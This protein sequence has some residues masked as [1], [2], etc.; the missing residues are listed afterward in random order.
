M[1]NNPKLLT[2]PYVKR[3]NDQQQVEQH[4][5]LFGCAFFTVTILWTLCEYPK[6]QKKKK[7]IFKKTIRVPI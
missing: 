2:R 7:H 1:N 5:V 4:D 3:R 6:T